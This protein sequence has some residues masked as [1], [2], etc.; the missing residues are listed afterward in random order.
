VRRVVTADIAT[1]F[2]GSI[3]GIVGELVHDDQVGLLKARP[4]APTPMT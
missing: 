4:P 1:C 3:D 2:Y